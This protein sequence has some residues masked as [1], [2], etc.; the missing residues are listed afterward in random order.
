MEGRVPDHHMDAPG[1][2]PCPAEVA[3]HAV[4]QHA[5]ARRHLGPGDEVLGEGGSVAHRFHRLRLSAGA[6]RVP[7]QAARVV[8]EL[9]PQLAHQPLQHLS[10][11]GHQLADGPDAIL[12]QDLRKN[13]GMNLYSFTDYRLH[14]EQARHP[15]EVRY[16]DGTTREAATC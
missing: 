5:D 4:R 2:E 10:G 15:Y 11:T 9:A 16:L 7:V 12:P 13:G 8:V 1:V 3:G 6:H 14:W